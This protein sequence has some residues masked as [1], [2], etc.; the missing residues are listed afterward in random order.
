MYDQSLVWGAT[1]SNPIGRLTNMST[2]T[3]TGAIFSYDPM[4]RILMNNQC[5][6]LNC[7]QTGFSVQYTYDLA[8]NMKT[9]TDGVGE[10]YTQSFDTVGRV[11]QLSSSWVDSQH[12][13]TLATVDSTVGY[14]PHGALRKMTLGNGLTQTAAFNKNLQPCRINLNSTATALATCSDAIPSGTC[15]TPITASISEPRTTETS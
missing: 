4:G 1:I 5:T 7:A 9:Y 2:G 14:Y 6:P 11:T 13:A 10:T 12:P 8:G 3:S 15:K